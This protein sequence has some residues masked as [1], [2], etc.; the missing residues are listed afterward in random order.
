MGI[1]LLGWA[2]FFVRFHNVPTGAIVLY[3][4]DERI[5]TRVSFV[6]IS[7]N[8]ADTRRIWLGA[9]AVQF[10]IDWN[11]GASAISIAKGSDLVLMTL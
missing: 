7:W 5:P 11:E 10:A 4:C 9:I 1:A 8:H 3:H 2:F 6:S